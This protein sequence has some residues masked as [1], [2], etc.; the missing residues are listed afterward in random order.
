MDAPL[1]VE[2]KLEYDPT[3]R[4]RLLG[5]GLLAAE[6][7]IVKRLFATYFDTPDLR[8][9]SAGY[10]LRIRRDEAMHIQTVKAASVQAAGLFVRGEW[11]RNVSSDTPVLDETAGPLNQLFKS[12]TLAKITPL[13]TTDIERL[14][15]LIDH[16]DGSRIEYAID[17]GEVRAGSRHSP[18]SEIELE[19]KSGS[20]KALFDVARSINELIP[21]RLGVQSKSERGYALAGNRIATAAKAEPVRLDREM[22]VASAFA[23]IAGNCIRQYRLNEDLL[24]RS[25]S[26]EAIHQA[27]V[28]LRRMRSAFWL[29]SPLLKGSDKAALFSSELRWLAGELGNV[30]DIDVILP[31][32]EG[33]QRSA[34]TA[35]RE[36]RFADLRENLVGIRARLLPIAIAEW[37]A[38]GIWPDTPTDPLS[39]DQDI[40]GF[41]TDRLERL[42]KRIKR[43]GKG[44]AG[45]DDESRHQVRKDA[46][47]LRYAVEFFL[48]L[49]PGRKSRRRMDRFLDHLEALQDKLG[50]LNDRATAP[51]LFARLTLDITLP[52]LTKKDRRRLLEDAEDCIEA[53]I[54]SKRFWRS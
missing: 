24:L 23:T 4:E 16:A 29:F 30:R 52:P 54:D 18:V 20:S 46:K 3:D 14:A 2:L 27:R 43:N 8:L 28:A 13:F 47:K 1:E 39:Y 49:Y 5:S 36:R 6:G 51:D 37:L 50:E 41:A 33:P 12:G 25:G 45:L 26:A 15:G 10:A 35:I 48:G 44:L 17:R 11:E 53:L 42:R 19:L 34:L 31:K 38:T 40:R 9:D 21:L 7:R 22:T 32:L